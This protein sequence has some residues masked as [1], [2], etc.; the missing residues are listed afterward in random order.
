MFQHFA[1]FIIRPEC[2]RINPYTLSHQEG[3]VTNQSAAL[4]LVTVKQLLHDLVQHIGEQVEELVHIALG[5][6]SKAGQVDGSEA[7]VAATI[8]D[9]TGGV[10]YIAQNPS[11]TTHVGHLSFR[12]VWIVV[13]QVERCIHEGEVREQPLGTHTH[14]QTEQVIAWVF[15]VVVHALLDSENLNREDGRFAITETRFRSEKQLFD[16]EPSFPAGVQTI[17]DGGERHL[18]TCAGVHGVQVVN[19]ALH[20]LIGVT[21]RLL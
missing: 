16:C 9:L 7:Q 18:R 2:V 19:E 4:Y 8:A 10:V 12:T 1:N 5:F 14:G 20:G 17:I 11:S 6:D 13:L 3:E 15:G 21:L